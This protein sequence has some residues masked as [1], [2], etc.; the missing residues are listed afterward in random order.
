MNKFKLF[1]MGLVALV[2]TSLTSCL[3]GND[4][5]TNSTVV[6][7]GFFNVS[8]NGKVL[9]ADDDHTFSVSNPSFLQYKDGT[10]PG[11]V[12]AVLEI[13]LEQ[14]QTVEDIYNTPYYPVEIKNAISGYFSAFV[15]KESAK[16]STSRFS[17]FTPSAA[18]GYLNCMTESVLPETVN[19]SC[20]QAYVEKVDNNTMFIK[21]VNVSD[22][23]KGSL[24]YAAVSFPIQS[25]FDMYKEVLKPEVI[26]KNYPD[27]YGYKLIVNDQSIY[28][29]LGKIVK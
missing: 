25:I 5:P 23:S 7:T 1:F 13:V 16:E 22:T 10:T 29:N 11:R 21:V 17:G 6:M 12:M 9:T 4:D 2:M 20:F 19:G 27:Y 18:D 28:Y 15:E 14:G 3:P 26:D 8:Q 24:R